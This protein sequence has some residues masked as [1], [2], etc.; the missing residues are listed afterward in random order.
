MQLN[1]ATQR[2]TAQCNSIQLNTAQ[3]SEPN[4]AQRSSM[5]LNEA[6][7]SSMKLDEAQWSSVKFNKALERRAKRAPPGERSEPLQLQGLCWVLLEFAGNLAESYDICWK[8]L[9]HVGNRFAV[10]E[11]VAQRSEADS[12][13][14]RASRS[15]SRQVSYEF[16]G[17][18]RNYLEFQWIS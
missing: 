1:A 12:I 10:L 6:Q 2:N 4:E 5:N 7:W 3:Y 11:S 13:L 18:L 17:T 9:G 8:L 15:L 16:Q 14:E